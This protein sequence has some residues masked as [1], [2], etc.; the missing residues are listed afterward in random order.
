M[1]KFNDIISHIDRVA[2][3]VLGEAVEYHPAV[4]DMKPIAAI[5]DEGVEAFGAQFDVGA[6]ETQTEISLILAD[7]VGIKRGDRMI[8][9]QNTYFIGDKIADDGD[10]IRF[11]LLRQ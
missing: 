6:S 8:T 10:I 7:V 2:C 3:D 9:D 4:G 11:S 1:T 5:I